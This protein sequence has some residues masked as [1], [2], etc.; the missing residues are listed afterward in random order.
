[1][2]PDERWMRQ[3]LK[4]ARRGLSYVHPNPMVGAVLVKNNRMVG[5]GYHRRYGGPHA[6]VE[7][8]A[9]A[10]VKAKGATLY[11]NLEPCAHWGKTPPCV[12]AVI[13]AGIKRVVAAFRDPNP[14]VAGKGFR[15]LRAAGIAVVTGVLEE[16]A[17]ELNRAFLHWIQSRRPYV[18]LKTASSLDGKIATA[19]GES[20]W[21]TGPEARS[22][23]H[24]L[25]AEVDA[26][27]VGVGTILADDPLLTA[28]GR[29]RNPVRVIFDSRLR[30]PLKAHSLDASAPTWIL[31]DRSTPLRAA[32]K[33]KTGVRLQAIRR[34]KPGRLDIKAALDW[35]GAQGITHLLVEG[36]GE[37]NSAFLEADLV[38]ELIWFVA[39]KI[40]GGKEARTAVEGQGIFRL[41]QAQK[42]TRFQVTRIGQDLCIRGSLR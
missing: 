22:A 33:K 39:P 41:A 11:L 26:I 15:K 2:T 10:G 20:K 38:D 19:K 18:T 29:G 21:I 3:A 42:L 9:R 27:A 30:T 36:G 16:E 23:G 40:I 28:H 17:R 35:L 8:L 32:F 13:A 6:E 4:L 14:K 1:M 37:I 12:D 34:Q 7:A 24:R 25:R 31:I 5:A